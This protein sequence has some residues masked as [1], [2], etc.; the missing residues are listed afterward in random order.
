MKKRVFEK[1]LAIIGIVLAIVFAAVL[2]T[3]I[4]G[5]I[6]YQEFDN[7]LVRGL[8]IILS[9]IYIIVS[10]L[11]LINL[12]SD[13]DIVKE[14]A[15]N[16]DRTGSTK[17]TSSTIKSLIRKHLKT[18]EGV[19]CG[20]ISL[21]LN[22]YGVSL[23]INVKMNDVEI[24]ET[25]TYIKLLLDNVF[26]TTLDYKFHSIDFKVQKLKSNYQPPAEELKEEAESEVRIERAA[27]RAKE[28]EEKAKIKDMN[29][30]IIEKAELEV[31]EESVE[32]EN[33][34]QEEKAE[35]IPE[36][37]ATPLAEEDEDN[38]PNEEIRI[39]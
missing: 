37:Q 20:K 4:F 21:V 7:S 35:E 15:V 31:N 22:E 18:I 2:L 11:S 8:F 5:G 13:N 23:R 1:I 26:E 33:D 12:F 24:K 38:L 17:A 39:D 9:V 27:R 30:K 14:I 34:N 3:T 10:A 28:A 25:T 19:K 36:I 29:E 6:D 16:R 32:T